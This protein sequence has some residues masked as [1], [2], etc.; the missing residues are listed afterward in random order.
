MKDALL[1]R[2]YALL[3]MVVCLIAVGSN[4]GIVSIYKRDEFLGLWREK[5]AIEGG[6]EFY[7]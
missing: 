6:G 3:M 7:Y 2:V 4:S 1:V 5:K